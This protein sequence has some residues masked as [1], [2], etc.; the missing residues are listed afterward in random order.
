MKTGRPPNE[1]ARRGAAG[2]QPTL[3]AKLRLDKDIPSGAGDAC[4]GGGDG[5]YFASARAAWAA[6]MRAVGTR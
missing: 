4:T 2:V 3:P 5:G 6:A 1:N